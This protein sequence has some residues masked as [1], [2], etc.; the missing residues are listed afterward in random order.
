[1]RRSSI[2]SLGQV[3]GVYEWLKNEAMLS[4]IARWPPSSPHRKAYWP[5]IVPSMAAHS[6]ADRTTTDADSTTS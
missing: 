3:L 2:R 4:A 6:S 1:M 5:R